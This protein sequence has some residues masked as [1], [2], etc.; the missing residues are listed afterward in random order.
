M[1]ESDPDLPV[2]VM[3]ASA[4]LALALSED[5]GLEVEDVL[6]DIIARN[7]QVLVPPLFWYEVMNGLLM[8]VRRGRISSED[9]RAIEADFYRLPLSPDQT[10]SAFIRQRIRE[11]AL[12][13]HLTFY[14][15]SYLELALRYTVPLLT[16][17]GHL[18]ALEDCYPEVIL[19]SGSPA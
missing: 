11:L 12:G 17:D 14:D 9:L 18:L 16:M 19:T 15:A 1:S 2:V 10:P 6:A 3:D 13:H 5:R 8:A 4:S 7:G